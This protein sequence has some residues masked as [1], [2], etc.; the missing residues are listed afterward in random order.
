MGDWT[1]LARQGTRQ[2]TGKP[3]LTL[4]EQMSLWELG[5]PCSTLFSPLSSLGTEMLS[6]G[7]VLGL[8]VS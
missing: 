2:V 1:R 8:G 5:T 4:V 3:V 6:N 7:A